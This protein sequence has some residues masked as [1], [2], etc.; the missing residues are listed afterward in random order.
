MRRENDFEK[1][2]NITAVLQKRRQRTTRE[3][4]GDQHTHYTGFQL[5]FFRAF[6]LRLL[7][8]GRR[9]GLNGRRQ[10]RHQI[11]IWSFRIGL[12][13]HDGFLVITKV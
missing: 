5:D 4:V 1:Q 7:A 3:E 11:G 10:R 2:L 6:F 9:S 12:P 8:R 13:Q